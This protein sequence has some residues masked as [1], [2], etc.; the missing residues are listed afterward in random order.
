MASAEYHHAPGYIGSHNPLALNLQGG[1]G[2]WAVQSL[3]HEFQLRSLSDYTGPLYFELRNVVWDEL[4]TVR[5]NII[6]SGA[7]GV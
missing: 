1:I 7:P 6:G 4:L 3:A 2:V 5:R